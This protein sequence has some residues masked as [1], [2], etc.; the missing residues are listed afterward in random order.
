ME[1]PKHHIF[2][3]ASFRASGEPQGACHKKG[4]VGLLQYLQEALLDRDMNEVTVSMT[5]CLKVC[6]RGP[7]MIIYPENYWYG[8]VEGEDTID[9]I[10]DALAEGKAEENYLLAQK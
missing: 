5:G 2:V 4:S 3:C 8:N 10:L 6:D 1:K 7:A 9:K